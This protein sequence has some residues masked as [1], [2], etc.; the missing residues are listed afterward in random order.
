MP[1]I[2]MKV[3]VRLDKVLKDKFSE[4]IISIAG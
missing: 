1:F 4:N 2:N 3:N